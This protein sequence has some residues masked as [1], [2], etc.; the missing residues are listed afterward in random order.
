[1][2]RESIRDRRE[3]ARDFFDLAIKLRGL[4]EEAANEH[5]WNETQEARMA[6]LVFGD[7]L[8]EDGDDVTGP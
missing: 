1:M 6:A 7:G 5:G 3:A 4:W 2:D 8:D